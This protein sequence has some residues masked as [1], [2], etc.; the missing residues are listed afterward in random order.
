[1]SGVDIFEPAVP[2]LRQRRYAIGRRVS[3][4]TWSEEFRYFLR[5]WAKYVRGSRRT[6]IKLAEHQGQYGETY[7]H[8]LD[9]KSDPILSRQLIVFGKSL[10]RHARTGTLI[11]L[12]DLL[13]RACG[14]RAIHLLFAALRETFVVE[15]RDP[16]SA[17]HSPLGSD[18]DDQGEFPLH[19]DLYVPRYLF[20]IFDDVAS[21]GSGASVFL[22]VGQFDRVLHEVTSIPAR[23]RLQIRACL[24]ALVTSDRYD[25][26]YDLL[27]GI[28]HPWIRELKER[29]RQARQ[30]IPFERG[31]GYLLDDRRWL[32]GREAPTGRVSRNRIHRLIFDSPE[33]ASARRRVVS[34]RPV[35]GTAR[36]VRVHG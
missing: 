25:E 4:L 21:D 35:R 3:W 26:F 22:G 19:A 20:N 29:L 1:M 31:Q 30:R 16:R 23:V 13:N 11:F 32:H 8:K 36:S 7:C 17:L 14:R 27:Y 28:E 9:T 6:E 10:A 2:P 24:G 34:V 15:Y 18:P 12:D 33:T 5:G